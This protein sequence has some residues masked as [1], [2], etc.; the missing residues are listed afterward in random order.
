MEVWKNGP[1]RD[2][3]EEE[4]FG[5][6]RCLLCFKSLVCLVWPCS[7]GRPG[8]PGCGREAKA[9]LPI[10]QVQGLVSVAALRPRAFVIGMGTGLT[11]VGAQGYSFR[12]LPSGSSHPRLATL[13]VLTNCG[14]NCSALGFAFY[15]F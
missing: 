4:A 8:T 3:K 13:E 11:G 7:S 15:I 5:S 6:Q 1:S 9:F 2:R 14:N 12:T 10:P